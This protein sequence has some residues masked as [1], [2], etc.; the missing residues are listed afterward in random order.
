MGRMIDMLPDRP[1]RCDILNVRVS[2]LLECHPE[3]LPILVDAGFTPLANPSLR[4]T[5]APKVTLERAFGLR[6]V[7]GE[8]RERFVARIEALCVCRTEAPR[9]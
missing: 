4:A 5:L 8:K 6:G 2:V 3:V 7:T 9:P 1:T